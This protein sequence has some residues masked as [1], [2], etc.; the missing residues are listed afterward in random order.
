MNE[1]VIPPVVSD[2]D[3]ASTGVSRRSLLRG[4][5]LAAGG[6]ALLAVSLTAQSAEAGN[7]TQKA[8]GYQT[9][10]KDGKQCSTCSLF[11]AP[12]ACKLVAG[13]IVA[14][15]WCRFYVKKA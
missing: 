1:N 12:N 9:T 7:M 2:E 6:A 14:T 11:Q 15:G 5:T 4:A 10:P 8:A 13:E 3:G